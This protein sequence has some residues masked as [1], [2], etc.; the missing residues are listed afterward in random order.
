MALVRAFPSGQSRAPP[1]STAAT[2]LSWRPCVRKSPV[3]NVKGC[4]TT[5]PWPPLPSFFLPYLVDKGSLQQV[6]DSLEAPVRMVRKSGSLSAVS[7]KLVQ[8]LKGNQ[9]AIHIKG[10]TKWVSWRVIDDPLYTK[11]GSRRGI[12]AVPI[13]RRTMAPRPSRWG[14]LK[15]V[16]STTLWDPETKQIVNRLY[17]LDIVV[18]MHWLQRTSYLRHAEEDDKNEP[19]L[20]NLWMNLPESRLLANIYI[21]ISNAMRPF[22]FI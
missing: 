22:I 6:G 20:T 2:R 17:S 15:T 12:F 13:E 5:R 21:Y 11:K 3:N 16:W 4:L 9:R 10:S 19:N 7:A 14:R 18:T 8:H 1:S